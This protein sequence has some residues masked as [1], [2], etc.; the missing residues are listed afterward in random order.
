MKHEKQ[1]AKVIGQYREWIRRQPA[2]LA[3]LPELTGRRLLC[4]CPPRRACHVDVLQSLWDERSAA[5]VLERTCPAEAPSPCWDAWQVYIDNLDILEIE[6][7]FVTAA[8]QLNG[9]PEAIRLALRRYEA[10]CVPVSE[11]K[12]VIRA[13]EGTALGD[14]VDGLQGTIGPPAE[15][16]RK[17]VSL[18]LHTLRRPRVTQRWLQV[19]AGRWVRMMLYRRETMTCFG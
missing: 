8:Q 15:Y 3:R 12:E 18:T 9:L 13:R 19:L 7:D 11:G 1:R 14:F 4:H 16:C 5:E 6:P 2:L 10:R 17:V